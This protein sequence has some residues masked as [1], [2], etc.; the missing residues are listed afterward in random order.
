MA[1]T[2][3]DSCCA[4][5]YIVHTSRV[6]VSLRCGWRTSSRPATAKPSCAARVRGKPRKSAGGDWPSRRRLCAARHQAHHRDDVDAPGSHDNENGLPGLRRSDAELVK[7]IFISVQTGM[8]VRD[9]LRCGVLDRILGHPEARVVLLTPGVRDAAFCAEF[10][11]ERVAIVPQVAYAPST[12]V[13]RLMVRRWRH[14][15]SAGMADAI[16]RLEERLISVPDAYARLFDEYAPS[17]V[18]SGD[19]LRPGDANLIAAA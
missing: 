15:T 6:A 17:L 11:S 4:T 7:T 8:V 12:M 2:C 5:R 14:V 3:C 19:P 1:S 13:L 9:L 10:A 16:H 18:V